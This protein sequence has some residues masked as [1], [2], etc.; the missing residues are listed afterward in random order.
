MTSRTGGDREEGRGDDKRR[1]DGQKNEK[2]E[3]ET[4]KGTEDRRTS[5]DGEE[6]TDE[7][8]RKKQ[9]ED[10]RRQTETGRK[11]KRE[12][13]SRKQFKSFCLLSSHLSPLRNKFAIDTES[14]YEPIKMVFSDT[15]NPRHINTFM[16]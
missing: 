14:V 2:D 10:R 1:T 16:F 3:K 11:K 5:P 13:V 8:N 12:K 15:T 6:E 7:T 4:R 9:T